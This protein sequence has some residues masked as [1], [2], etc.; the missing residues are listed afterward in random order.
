M[1]RSSQEGNQAGQ[2]DSEAPE[3]N[4][5]GGATLE[6]RQEDGQMCEAVMENDQEA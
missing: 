6:D 4:K 5:T 1:G 2:N 3:C